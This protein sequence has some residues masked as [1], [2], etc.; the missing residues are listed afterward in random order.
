VISVLETTSSDFAQMEANTRAQEVADQ[1][2]YDEEM[3]KNSI[4]LARR[5]KESDMKGEEKKRLLSKITDLNSQKKHVSDEVEATETYEKDLQKACVD[6]DSSY[7][8]RKA[9]R[10]KEMDALRKAQ[11]ILTDAFKGKSFLQKKSRRHMALS[12]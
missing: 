4:E 8:D 6:G 9:A 1:N 11:D 2:A 10:A 3:K 5:Q 12:I 7:D